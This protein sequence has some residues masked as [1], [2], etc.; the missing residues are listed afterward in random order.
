MEVY[1]NVVTDLITGRP[2]R[3]MVHGDTVSLL[4]TVLKCCQR[5]LRYL[6]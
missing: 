5:W 3:V 4:G 6:W 2:V 1:Q